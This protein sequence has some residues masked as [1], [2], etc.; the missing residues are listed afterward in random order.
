MF[1]RG[2]YDRDVSDVGDLLELL[3]GASD[4]WQTVRCS[5]RG[6]ND[7]ELQRRA[8]ER[9]QA[10]QGQGSSQVMMFGIGEHKPPP[11]EYE[12]T[13][14]VWIVKP[15]R[16]REESEHGTTVS[17]GDLWWSWSE[18]GGLMSNEK[19]RELTGQ[20]ASDAHP[21]HLSP[22]LLI[23]GLRFG[24]IERIGDALVAT[25]RPRGIPHVHFGQPVHG[26]DEHRLTVDAVRGVVLRIESF[27][28][29]RLFSS[30]QLVDAVFD[31]PIPD[32]V[33]VLERPEGVE[34]RSPRELSP[35][36]TLEEAAELAPFPVFAI[37]ELPE[38][39]WRHHV[40]YHR[41]PRAEDQSVHITYHRA[42]ARGFITLAQ[43]SLENRSSAQALGQESV[44]VEREGT[45]ITVSSETYDEAELRRLAENAER[46]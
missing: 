4:R 31:E 26:A 14:R 27:I 30:S 3:Y 10:A 18:H 34:A 24:T 25:A 7:T 21:L 8:I 37:S 16:L 2:D 13:Q 36:V 44:Q 39:N 23:P 32:E 6:W 45:R 41:P 40:H 22:A 11:R 43:T 12:F 9:W 29:G 15:D 46:V 42:D 19:D 28:D 1:T 38:G 35:R 20:K 17:H 5:V 33:F